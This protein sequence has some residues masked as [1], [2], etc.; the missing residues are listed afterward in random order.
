LTTERSLSMKRLLIIFTLLSTHYLSFSQYD[1]D[2]GVKLGAAG[3]LGDI[4]GQG[5]AQPFI[6]DIQLQMTRQNIGVFA[7]KRIFDWLYLSAAF[8]QGTIAGADSLSGK[9]TRFS[10]NLSFRNH[11]L[12]ANAKV[13]FVFLRINDF[14]NTGMHRVDFRMYAYAGG[15]VFFH[16]PKAYY[17]GQWYALQPLRTEGK[18]YGLIQPAIPV[19]GGLHFTVNRNI[20]IGWELG[21]RLTFTDYL[22]DVSTFYISPDQHNS[23]IG[24]ILADRSFEVRADHPLFIGTGAFSNGTKSMPSDP[25]PRGNPKNNDNY[26]FTCINV[27]YVIR[28]KSNFNKKKYDFV[29]TNVRKVKSKA[30]F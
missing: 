28:G 4:G 7:R 22:D 17:Q 8:E 26:L 5:D 6:N 21:W 10:R 11:I 15:A 3:Y 14:G 16:N 29:R 19:G 13:E 30:K 23:E 24:R 1:W 20:R 18:K 9:D 27:S 2:F 25:A 12:E